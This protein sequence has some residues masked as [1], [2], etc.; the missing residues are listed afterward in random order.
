MKP[1]KVL[2]VEDDMDVAASLEILL[3]LE[4]T[5]VEH[6]FSAEAA[7]S[8]YPK[9][10]FDICLLDNRLRGMQGLDCLR[11]FREINPD[12]KVVIITAYG[13]EI[14]RA[15]VLQAGGLEMLHKPFVEDKLTDILDTVRRQLSD[16]DRA[17]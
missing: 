2:I 17:P 12:A 15:Q 11:R 10:D 8:R 9:A 3:K 16:R 7:L 14:L 4:G 1:L 6:V 13:D 5:E